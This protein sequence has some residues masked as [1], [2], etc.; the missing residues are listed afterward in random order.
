MKKMVLAALLAALILSGCKDDHL[1][2]WP[3]N[4]NEPWGYQ[5][6]GDPGYLRTKAEE[7]D[8]WHLENHQPYHGG[9]VDIHFQDDGSFRIGGYGDSTIWTGTYLASQAMRYYVT[10]DDQARKNVLRMVNTLSHH[11]HVTGQPGFIAR[12]R[13]PQYIPAYQGDDWCND[14]AR[15]FKISEG[16]YA[17][18]WWWGET[19]R[20]QYIGWM[21]GMSM[22]YDLVQ[23]EDDPELVRM[24][25]QIQDDVLEVLVMLMASNWNII[26]QDNKPSKTAPDL[27]PT[28]K[29]AFATIGYHIT[30]NQEIKAALKEMLKDINRVQYQFANIN[31]L[32]RYSQ[33][34]GN[35]LGHSCWYNILRLGRVY[36]SKA[37]YEWMV[38]EFNRGQH[39][40]TRLSHNAWFNGIYMS[41]GGWQVAEDEYYGQLLGALTDFPDAPN[42]EYY[43]PP[44]DPDTYELDPFSL[45]LTELYTVLPFMEEIMGSVQPQALEAFE[46]PLQC[47]SGFLWQRNPFRIDACGS[48]KPNSINPGVDYLVAYWLASYHKLIDKSM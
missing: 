28:Y 39:N 46:V 42:T 43:L 35:N 18:D 27:I 38:Q 17:G 41:Q 48:D 13:A 33:Y 37:D 34:Y 31:F 44:R 7:F 5:E 16:K 19:S 14:M 25:E 26:A 12:Y 24:R 32:N 21:L 2:D 10:G 23:D 3:Q 6:D 9:T 11:L 45:Q 8:I 22:A 1:A 29:L 4:P 30:G 20:D 36:Y 47:S 40:F 15:C